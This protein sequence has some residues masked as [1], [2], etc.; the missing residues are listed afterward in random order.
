MC[1]HCQSCELGGKHEGVSSVKILIFVGVSD[2]KVK[3]ARLKILPFYLCMPKY[4]EQQ[5]MTCVKYFEP[6]VRKQ[7]AVFIFFM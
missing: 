1:A 6:R 3:M 5:P 2:N 4:R 7:N